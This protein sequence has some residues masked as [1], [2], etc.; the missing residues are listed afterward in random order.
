MTSRSRPPRIPDNNSVNEEVRRLQKELERM[1]EDR[2]HQAI[3][4]LQYRE[5]TLEFLLQIGHMATKTKEN[6]EL[7]S[8]KLKRKLAAVSR[9]KLHKKE[10]ED[11]RRV[12][13][14]EREKVILELRSRLEEQEKVILE[15]QT[16]LADAEGK[17][18]DAA[19][20]LTEARDILKS[21]P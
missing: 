21:K 9:S 2:D 19:A 3:S 12:E 7:V 16:R 1:K 13:E 5:A 6:Q 15:L 17:Q 20:K 10:L 8:E 4:F 18:I 14:A 11:N